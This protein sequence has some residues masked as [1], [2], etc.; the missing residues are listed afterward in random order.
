[1]NFLKKIFGSKTQK[2]LKK[3]SPLIPVIND[4]EESYSLLDDSE[5]RN[6]RE[7]FIKRFEEGEKLDDLLPEAF[8][9]VRESSRKFEKVRDKFEKARYIWRKPENVIINRLKD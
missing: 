5:L 4:L 8:A 6:L 7:K 2:K 1:M 3:I 9:A